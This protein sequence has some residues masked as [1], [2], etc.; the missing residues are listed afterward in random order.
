[1][2]TG[3]MPRTGARLKNAHLPLPR[4]FEAALEGET[5]QVQEAAHFVWRC[6]RE[7][8]DYARGDDPSI[9]ILVSEDVLER[10]MREQSFMTPASAHL[11]L[12]RIRDWR[13][14]RPGAV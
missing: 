8:G 14:C 4:R 2:V 1:M 12:A 9:A 5:K 13:K 11:H 6:V 10:I 7:F 3:P